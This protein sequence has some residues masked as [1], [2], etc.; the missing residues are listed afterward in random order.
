MQDQKET[1]P[2]P[3]PASKQAKSSKKAKPTPK[4]S[5]AEKKA[6]KKQEIEAVSRVCAMLLRQMEEYKDNE[7]PED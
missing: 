1:E 5:L 6:L 4:K 2:S 7:K 3:R